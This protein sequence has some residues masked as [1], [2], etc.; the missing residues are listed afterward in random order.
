MTCI[1]CLLV[2]LIS[3]VSPSPPWL[4]LLEGG[5]SGWQLRNA[6]ISV[7]KGSR[8]SK[9]TPRQ[10][11]GELT[12][13]GISVGPGPLSKADF[14]A[15]EGQPR[16]LICMEPGRKRRLCDE[17]LKEEWREL[18]RNYSNRGFCRKIKYQVVTSL[19]ESYLLAGSFTLFLT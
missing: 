6:G 14:A 18:P 2:M 11:E 15:R 17:H 16:G 5:D 4:R 10:G 9:N 3:L 1:R 8:E 12:E 19:Y 13:N 7:K